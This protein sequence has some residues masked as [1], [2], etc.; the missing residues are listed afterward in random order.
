M[1]KITEDT[2]RKWNAC[3]EC[4]TRFCELFPCGA[5]LEIASEKLIEDGHANWSNW[6]WLRCKED[7]EYFDQTVVVAVNRGTAKAGDGGTAKAG[8]GGTAS[9]GDWGTATAGDKGTASAGLYGSISIEF[10]DGNVYRRKSA[11]IDGEKMK[12]NTKYRI[13]NGEFVE[14]K[15]GVCL[16][17]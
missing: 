15:D 4:Y 17:F 5:R 13:K 12:A 2:L 14:V 3:Q 9:A 8:D 6:L 7:S 16:S 10:Y 11:D 1:K